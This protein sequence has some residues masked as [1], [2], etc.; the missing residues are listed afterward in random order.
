MGAV[1][2]V[3]VVLKRWIWNERCARIMEESGVKFVADLLIK[4]HRAISTIFLCD[5]ARR[6]SPNK[7]N[8]PYMYKMYWPVCERTGLGPDQDQLGLKCCLASLREMQLQNRK[9]QI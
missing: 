7:R 8:Q 2:D 5:G 9:R 4:Y 1:S 3:V 6:R